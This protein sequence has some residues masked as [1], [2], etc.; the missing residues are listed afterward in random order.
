MFMS[1]IPLTSLI[2]NCVTSCVK[3]KCKL[4][5]QQCF[6]RVISLCGSAF[7]GAILSWKGAPT[8]FGIV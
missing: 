6:Y 5:G 8:E 2:P 7:P 3:T 1:P 4:V